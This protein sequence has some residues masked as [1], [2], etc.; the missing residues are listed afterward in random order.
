MQSYQPV[1]Q[2]MI[3]GIVPSIH[4][5]SILIALEKNDAESSSEEEDE[6]EGEEKG[7]EEDEDESSGEEN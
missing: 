5:H 3:D 4:L 7:D 1:L 2:Q 6:E